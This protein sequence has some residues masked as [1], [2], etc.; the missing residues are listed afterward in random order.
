[1]DPLYQKDSSNKLYILTPFIDNISLCS[2]SNSYTSS[3]ISFTSL[4]T[5]VLLFELP[6]PSSFAFLSIRNKFCE[7]FYIVIIRYYCLT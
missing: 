2:L 6:F 7:L 3:I 5:D 4:F 1:M